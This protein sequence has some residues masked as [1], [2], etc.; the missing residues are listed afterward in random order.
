MGD[1]LFFDKEKL[2][3]FIKGDIFDNQFLNPQADELKSENLP[4]NL[5]SIQ[6]LNQLRGH[7]RFISCISVFHLFDFDLQTELAQ[8]LLSLL[9]KKVSGSTIFGSHIGSDQ[10]GLIKR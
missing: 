9:K 4:I 6:S 2:I 10:K 5:H 8:R 3:T 1:K 7:L